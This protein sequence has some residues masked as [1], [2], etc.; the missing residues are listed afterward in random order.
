MNH[1]QQPF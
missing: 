1:Y